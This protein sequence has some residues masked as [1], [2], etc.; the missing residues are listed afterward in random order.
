MIEIKEHTK[1]KTEKKI[2]NAEYLIKSIAEQG[3]SLESALADLIDNSLTANSSTIEVLTDISNGNIQLFLADDGDGMS[4]MELSKNMEFPSDLMENIRAFDDLGRFGLGMKTASFSQT[5]KLTVLSRPKG[6]HNYAARTWDVDQ[7]KNWEIIINTEQDIEEFLSQYDHLQS[8]KIGKMEDFVPNTI[9][10]WTG[11]YKFNSISDFRKREEALNKQLNEVTREYLGLVFHR[12]MERIENPLKIKLNNLFVDPF[13]PFPECAG[14]RALAFEQ[15]GMQND[16]ISIQGFVLPSDAIKSKDNKYVTE[17]RGLLDLEGMYLYRADRIIMFGGWNG[18]IK[19]RPNIQL[20]RLKIEVGNASDALLQLNVAKSNVVIPYDLKM[21][22]LRYVGNLTEQARKEYFNREIT[23][24]N[25]TDKKLDLLDR[26]ASSK[27]NVVRINE[28]YPIY[29]ELLT[30]MPKD[31]QHL[32]KNLIR[33]IETRI[34]KIRHI[35]EKQD[36]V[37]LVDKGEISQTD[38]LLTIDKLIKIGL[39]KTELVS[40]VEQDLGL[41]FE[42]LPGEV[43]DKIETA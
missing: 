1:P 42:S 11:M 21:G 15:Y 25:S 24:K 41:R 40:I 4:E 20:A 26:V 27:G 36:F 32:L 18:I 43:K 7:I 23:N 34:N 14:L 31:K 10:C 19:K 16:V 9:I 2:P 12:F 28:E 13:N 30:H 17:Y 6:A 37:A 33:S 8:L 22:F 39:S 38:T 3:Y 35:H 29:K 5:R